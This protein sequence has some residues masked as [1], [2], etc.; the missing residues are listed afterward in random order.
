MLCGRRIPLNLKEI[1]KKTAI[2]PS[3]LYG[4]ECWGTKKQH[5]YRISAAEMR[6]LSMNAKIRKDRIRN[7]CIHGGIA[8]ASMGEKLIKMVW[9]YV[10]DQ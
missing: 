6:M 10:T 1:S 4:D 8:V 5:I 2:R 7:E 3:M 9:S